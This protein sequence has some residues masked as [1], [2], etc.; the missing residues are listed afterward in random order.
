MNESIDPSSVVFD[1]AVF[2]VAV[3][4]VGRKFVAVTNH[5]FPPCIV[6]VTDD[7]NN[8][9]TILSRRTLPHVVRYYL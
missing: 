1:I 7:A 6:S 9:D 2:D 3:V 8:F 5:D 4:R